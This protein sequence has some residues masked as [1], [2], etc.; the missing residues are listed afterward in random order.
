MGSTMNANPSNGLR[1]KWGQSR[2]SCL[3]LAILGRVKPEWMKI[4][5][6]ERKSRG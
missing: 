2:I 3:P 4:A 1:N 5:R 6:S